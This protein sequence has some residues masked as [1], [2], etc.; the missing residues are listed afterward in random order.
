M[1]KITIEKVND[2]LIG[3]LFIVRQGDKYTEVYFEEAMA[4]VCALMMQ[5][6]DVMPQRFLGWMMTEEQLNQQRE[7]IREAAREW[8]EGEEVEHS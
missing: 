7:A 4:V 8:N 6:S 1:E 3:N 2:S 5:D